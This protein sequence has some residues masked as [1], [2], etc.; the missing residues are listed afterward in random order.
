LTGRTPDQSAGPAPSAKRVAAKADRLRDLIALALVLAG[1]ALMLVS[2]SG[3]QQLAT[4]PIVL[5]KGEPAF[6]QY[7]HYK[8]LDYAGRAVIVIGIMV[9]FA[10]YLIHA[11]RGA[12]PA[13]GS[14][15]NRP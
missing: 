13:A 4:Q 1:I 7:N 5:A 3:M 10:S 11:R 8:Y 14:S 12:A 15:Q 6:A 9:G 2:H